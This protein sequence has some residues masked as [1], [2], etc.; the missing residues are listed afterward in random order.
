MFE[1]FGKLD[2][3]TMK[4]MI[5]I[6]AYLLAIT[7]LCCSCSA[8]N[9]EKPPENGT[10][11]PGTGTVESPSNMENPDGDHSTSSAE[12]NT[13]SDT[14]SDDPV[15]YMTTAISPEGLMAIYEA[16]DW[17]P[18]NKVAV[19]LSTGEPGSNYLRTDLI[20]ELVQS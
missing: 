16:L 15:V 10:E 18:G 4:Q 1:N 14:D 2:G 6:V 12:T 9:G 19:K 17:T 3:D 13:D 20:G 7:L 8:G 5:R 11:A